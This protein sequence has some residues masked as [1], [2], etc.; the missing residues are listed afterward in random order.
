[1]Y[2]FSCVTESVYL[3][4]ISSVLH[5]YAISSTAFLL[6]RCAY[7]AFSNPLDRSTPSHRY[8]GMIPKRL[9]AGAGPLYLGFSAKKIKIIVKSNVLMKNYVSRA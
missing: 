6:F 1:M 2:S 9:G 8:P 7:N 4:Y 5:L 3:F